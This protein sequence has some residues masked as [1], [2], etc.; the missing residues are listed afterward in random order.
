[1]PDEKTPETP[2]PGSEEDRIS[3][4]GPADASTLSLPPKASPPSQIGPYKI[5][6]K[7]GEG[8]MGIVYLAEQEKPFRRRVA[9]KVIKLG[10][11][12]NE[13]LARFE[14]ERQALAIMNHPN[15]A[16]IF[17]AGA[18]GQGR[19]YFVM[20]LV[21]GVPITE[22]CDRQRLTTKERLEL[23]M[24]A[25][26]GVQHAH[27]KGIIHRDIKSSNILV[28]FEGE[29]PVPKIIDF[30]VAKATEQRLTERTVFTELGQLIGT[31]EYMSP[32]QAE[33]TVQEIDTRTDV[34]SLGVLL[35]ELLVGALPF[36]P[37]EFRRVG[38]DEIRRRIREEEPSKPSTRFSTIGDAAR[39][40]AKRRRTDPGALTRQLRGDL[41]WITMRALEKDRA[42]RYGSPSELAADVARHLKNE[43]V[44]AGPPGAIYGLR[45]FALRHRFGVAA[46]GLVLLALLVGLTMATYGLV[47]AQRAEVVAREAKQEA[48]EEAERS[49]RE[50]EATREV[51]SLL[52]HLLDSFDAPRGTVDV[53][54]A[55]IQ[56]ERAE[57]V[58]TSK[59]AGHPLVQAELLETI[60]KV[61][62]S[63]GVVDP[64]ERI[65]RDAL[66]TRERVLGPSD[67][68]VAVN[69]VQLAWVLLLRNEVTEASQLVQR[70]YTIQ[71]ELL[72]PEHPDLGLTLFGIGLVS[73]LEGNPDEAKQLW[74]RALA[75]AER[76]PGE[77]DP[78]T[79]SA[80]GFLSLL[81]VSEGRFDEAR[82]LQ[83]RA[84]ALHER[85]Y[86]PDNAAEAG[87]AYIEALIRVKEENLVGAIS[88]LEDALDI[89]EKVLGLEH[90]ERFSNLFYLGH[91]LVFHRDPQAAMQ[92]FTEARTL[93]K[94]YSE[95]DEL[96]TQ[97]TAV[98]E[99]GILVGLASAYRMEGQASEAESLLSQ[100]LAVL[101]ENPLTPIGA[102]SIIEARLSA[103][104]EDHDGTL[105]HLVTAL[106]QRE[107]LTE[108]DDIM[109]HF[110]PDFEFLHG[111][112]EF[113]AIVAGVKKQIGEE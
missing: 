9:L 49:R 13:V 31:P 89:Q 90:P 48:V 14:S 88:L 74:F 58:V 110:D 27:Q 113:E 79:V 93:I 19:P 80:V 64:A 42:R 4:D 22:H 67:P 28:Q 102:I 41:D 78:G 46:S 95:T 70:A 111:D 50:A 15:I 8:G 6:E 10:M 1:M 85:A 62:R 33:M 112:P 99:A 68:V 34:Y 100:V 65:L 105:G 38:F 52:G 51:S 73:M 71:T 53:G 60:G 16:K 72:G 59:L 30:G 12:T 97:L 20:E 91:L 83:E 61:Y 81:L 29:K 87:D 92:R 26:E 82:Q 77:V 96:G 69:L 5:R 24:Q 106:S 76:H 36:D 45:K 35:Y 109:L 37:K 47:R 86:G 39:D 98:T 75:I 44:L 7:I 103:L 17:E 3:T 11:D 54:T 2:P 25:C 40:L 108:L 32:E 101:E 94:H 18:T 43:P 107:Q 56:L 63:F 104:R 57:R 23:F 84:S 21:K 55:R 66:G